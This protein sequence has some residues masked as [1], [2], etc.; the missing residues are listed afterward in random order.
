MDLGVLFAALDRRHL[1]SLENAAARQSFG[2]VSPVSIRGQLAPD[3]V[4]P[5]F[6]AL[7][8]N[9]PRCIRTS[10]QSVTLLKSSW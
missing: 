2:P 5:A 1:L 6:D 10:S 3:T 9:P 8:T 4:Q 7:S